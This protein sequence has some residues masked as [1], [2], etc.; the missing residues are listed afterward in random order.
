VVAQQAVGHPRAAVVPGDGEP[1]EAE[2]RH[3]L[4]LVERQRPLGIGREIGAGQRLRAVAIAAQIGRDDGE[5]LGQA[6]RHLAPHRMGLR[7]AVQQQQ[8][9]AA[10][11]GHQVD[12]RARGLDPLPA[13]SGEE[14]GH[15]QAAVSGGPLSSTVLP[16]GSVM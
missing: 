2:R 6:R 12:A 1:V 7:V 4:D 3:R 8:R 10:A 16:S 11:A 5:V 14:I 9:R 13:K 15:R